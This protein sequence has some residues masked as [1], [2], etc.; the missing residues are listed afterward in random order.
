MVA[1]S[2]L[3]HHFAHWSG[4]F[5]PWVWDVALGLVA[6]SLLLYANELRIERE[7]LANTQAM[8][9]VAAGAGLPHWELR[10]HPH[11]DETEHSLF[12]SIHCAE[13]MTIDELYLSCPR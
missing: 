10:I 9:V 3:A 12:I 4:G 6:V 13:Y 5:W 8:K 2:G 11:S 7:K 1:A